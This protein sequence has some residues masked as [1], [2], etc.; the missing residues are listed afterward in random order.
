MNS[1]DHIT[2][3]PATEADI[4][5][6]CEFPQSEE[7]LFFLFPKATYPLTYAQLK[8]A[9][10]QRA[11]STVFLFDGDIAGFSN[12]YVFEHNGRCS[13][14]NVIVNPGYRNRGV[15]RHIIEYMTQTAF[16]VYN[17]KEV[18]VSCFNQNTA[19]LLLYPSLGFV[20]FSLEERQDYQGKRVA[21][22]HLSKRFG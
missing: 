1:L 10:D 17:A 22:I 2:A 5:R 11:E 21:I 3:R 20:P 12:F 16:S 15:A 9:I 19:A 4:H 14:G 8:E 7:E 13:I 6:I 18:Q